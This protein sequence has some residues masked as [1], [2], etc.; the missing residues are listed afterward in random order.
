M[1][2]WSAIFGGWPN[3]LEG[4]ASAVISGVVAAVTAW[5]VVV[6][7]SHADRRRAFEDEGRQV[8]R[9]LA[10][11][12]VT[13]FIAIPDNRSLREDIETAAI[14]NMELRTAAALLARHDAKLGQKIQDHADAL[15]TRVNSWKQD[16]TLH[17]NAAAPRRYDEMQE[18]I[19]GLHELVIN[20]LGDVIAQPKSDRKPIT[21][22]TVEPEP[23]R[24]G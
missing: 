21:H 19:E 8:A 20:W 10:R 12:L 6:G 13:T 1:I 23:L 24:D 16:S 14:I 22:E 2:D 7:T 9:E 5:L 11:T 15:A 4:S 3:A 17:S 18:D